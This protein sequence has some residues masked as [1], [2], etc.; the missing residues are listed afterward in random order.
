M[1]FDKKADF[2]PNYL[3]VK[4]AG[5]ARISNC[6]ILPFLLCCSKSHSLQSFVSRL[7]G[8]G[9]TSDKCPVEI[10]PVCTRPAHNWSANLESTHYSVTINKIGTSVAIKRSC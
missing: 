9:N 7:S 3:T 4:N 2:Y 6:L 8:S 10:E 1:C 5:V